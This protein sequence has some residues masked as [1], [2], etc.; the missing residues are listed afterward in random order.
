ML[1]SW[2]HHDD[3][4]NCLCGAGM[5]LWHD[6]AGTAT[7]NLVDSDADNVST[8]SDEAGHGGER[9]ALA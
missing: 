6:G 4:L 8:E 7:V 2:Q 9:Q 1:G 5:N 3:H